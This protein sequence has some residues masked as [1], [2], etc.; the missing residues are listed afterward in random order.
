MRV[1]SDTS[2]LCNLARIGRLA[3]LWEQH[4]M[5]FIPDEVWTEL[6]CMRHREARESLEDA[7]ASGKLRTGT[8][9]DRVF[10]NTLIPLLDEGESAA[11]AL[12]SSRAQ[13]FCL[14]MNPTDARW[15]GIMGCE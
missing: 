10:M 11:I 2:P 1:C 4:P 7:R 3:L 8:V 6:G 15:P 14:W 5:V 9:R 12:L 13:T